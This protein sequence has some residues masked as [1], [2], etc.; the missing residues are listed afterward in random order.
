[1][2]TIVA[3]PAAATSTFCFCRPG[4]REA[5]APQRV[6]PLPQATTMARRRAIAPLH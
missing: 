6:W 5:D 2:G 1:M 3:D 4:V